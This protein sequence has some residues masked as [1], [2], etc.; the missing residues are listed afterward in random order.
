MTTSGGAGTFL[1]DGDIGVHRPVILLKG[2]CYYRKHNAKNAFWRINGCCLRMRHPVILL[3]LHMNL[4]NVILKE[5]FWRLTGL[6]FYFIE[7]YVTFSKMTRRCWWQSIC[8]GATPRA[9]FCSHGRRPTEAG[10]RFA[11]LTRLFNTSS[12]RHIHD[13]R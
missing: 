4:G 5:Y 13:H 3:K 2:T 1:L 10:G 6:A 12:K 8:C 7:S 9:S 11:H